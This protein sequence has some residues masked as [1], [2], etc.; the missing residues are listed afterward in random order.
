MQ[1][2]KGNSQYEDVVFVAA[3]GGHLS[4]TL[5]MQQETSFNLHS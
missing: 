1:G 3:V 5:K 2:I 4:E